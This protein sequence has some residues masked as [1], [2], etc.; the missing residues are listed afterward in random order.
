VVEVEVGVADAAGVVVG[1]AGSVAS[2]AGGP[3]LAGGTVG[4]G[5]F[6]L[7]V[8]ITTGVPA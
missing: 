1:A 6:G 2:A 3:G 5:A 4:A 7:D 8:A